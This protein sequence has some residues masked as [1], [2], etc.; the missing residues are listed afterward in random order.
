ML[1]LKEY[2]M[3]R[4][5]DRDVEIPNLLEFA[6]YYKDHYESVLDVGARFTADYY[7]RE[8]RKLAKWYGGV[9]PVLDKEVV[10]IVDTWYSIDAVKMPLE[11]V[12]FVISCSTIEHVGLYPIKYQDLP[13]ARLTFL[14]NILKAAK[15]YFWLSF[16]VGHEYV[17]PGELALI[18]E[19]EFES[20]EKLM[21]GCLTE[22]GFFWSDGPQAGFPWK[23]TDRK[24]AFSHQYD[25][26]LGTRSTC[27]IEGAM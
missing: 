16:P 11:P 23:P 24:T 15:K 6:R 1:K 5:T 19:E 10:G 22:V 21:T 2:P 20:W 27:I 4:K 14:T 7:A 3:I 26:K 8:I 25:E 18:T 9:D 13:H 12:D 17:C